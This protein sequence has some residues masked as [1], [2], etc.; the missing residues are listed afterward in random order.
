MLTSTFHRSDQAHESEVRGP[1]FGAMTT[2]STHDFFISAFGIEIGTLVVDL[3]YK[4]LY[5][6]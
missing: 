2:L 4:D 1:A 5:L 6:G 3:Y